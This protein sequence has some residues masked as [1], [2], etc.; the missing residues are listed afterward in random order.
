[1]LANG[2]SVGQ[3]RVI[4]PV[5]L[6]GG[7]GTRLWPLS[8]PQRPKQF[9]SLIGEKS[10]F[11]ETLA[12][13]SERLTY[14]APLVIANA[15]HEQ[16][17]ESELAE[18]AD[19]QLVLEPLARNTAVAIAIAANIVRETYGSD[20]LMLVLPSDHR[21]GNPD[22]F[23]QAVAVGTA[24]AINGRLVTFGVKPAG[25][26]TGF[27][28]IE[29]GGALDNEERVWSV[30]AFTEKPERAVAEA[31]VASGRHYWNGGI[32]LFAA[33]SLLDEVG[34]LAPDVA[35]AAVE[36]VTLG[37]REDQSFYPLAAAMVASPDISIDYAVME[38]TD[39]V[40]VVPLDCDW[41]DVGSWDALASLA[42]S[43]TTSAD[44]RM[45]D[46]KGC[47]TRT[48]GVQISLLGVEDLIVVASG[49]H[50]VVMRKGQSQRI[51]ELMAEPSP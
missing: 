21:I 40:A 6:S 20:A 42:G 38:K 30:E 33:G 8:T 22:A 14:T 15:A 34:R 46:T 4:T 43:E 32:F 19:A 3:G 26:E 10:L 24:A 23:Q 2:G 29:A 25:P 16:L 17:C 47:F 37:H 28:Y 36:A 7:S 48:D 31:M 50:V 12:R 45:I 35:K 13:V 18:H 5:I 41:S 51:K 11:A 1:M 39:K 49:G 44:V 9:L 27:G